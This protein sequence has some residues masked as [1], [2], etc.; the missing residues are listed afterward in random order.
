MRRIAKLSALAICS[1]VALTV[2]AQSPGGVT[3]TGAKAGPSKDGLIPAFAGQDKPLPGWSYGKFRGDYWKYKDEKP[4][5]SIDASNYMKYADKLSPGQIELFKKI[6]GYR[7]D[8][9][10]THRDCGYPD[11]VDANIKKNA[12]YAKLTPDGNHIQQAILPGLPFPAAKT[13]Q[14]AIWNYL[15]RYRGVG[16][17]WPKTYTMV[18]P[19]PGSNTWISVT[20]KQTMYY[21]WGKK[22]ANKLTP[23]ENLFSIYFAYETPAAF[24][25]QALVQ[26]YHFGDSNAE[27]FYY[28]PGQRRVRRM[29]SYNYD[30]PQIGFENQY[31]IDEAKL[32]N[33]DIDRFNWTLAGEKEMYV[34]Y[35]DFG[36][37]NF[38][39]SVG[40]VFKNND[41]D[42]SARRYELHRVYVLVATLK[43]NMRHISQK[44]VLYLD[45]DTY[46]ALAGEDYDAQ[47]K[48]YKVKEGYPIPVWELGGT[49][50]LEPFAQYNLTS[51]QYVDDQSVIGGGKDIRFFEESND[52]RFRGDYYTAENLRS[53]SER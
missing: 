27:S 4:L 39:K 53:I 20:S 23:D 14:E 16:T 47:G 34:P 24:A 26:N 51:G 31:T 15:S 29:P 28:F 6:K 44:K 38:K 22:G 43:P 3:V 10:P 5:F 11:W 19:R 17:E 35:N 8:I 13:G 46:L 49:C 2:W 32:F 52:P 50:E 25:G 48:L 37:F 30:A 12:T 41:V 9:Y 18:S 36:M 45:E 33:G 40:D 1:A 42:P 7:M 21:P